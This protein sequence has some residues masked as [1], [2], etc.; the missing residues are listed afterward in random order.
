M[1]VSTSTFMYL[2]SSIHLMRTSH[3]GFSSQ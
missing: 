2:S 3:L 1:N